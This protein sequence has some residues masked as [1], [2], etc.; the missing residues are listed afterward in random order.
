L[1]S[2]GGSLYIHLCFF[3]QGWGVSL[4]LLVYL[5]LFSITLMLSHSGSPYI[6]LHVFPQG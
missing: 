3:P 2:Y 4:D 1:V 5:N 6:H